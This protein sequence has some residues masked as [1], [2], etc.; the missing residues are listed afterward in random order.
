M[1]AK[2]L[3]SCPT[4]CDAMDSSLPGVSVHGILQARTLEWDKV[5]RKQRGLRPP[6]L[7]P[8]VSGPFVELPIALCWD[9]ASGGSQPLVSRSKYEEGPGKNIAFSVKNK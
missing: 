8:L 7:P 1:R 9:R 6:V 4:L 5:V 2:S 3:Q